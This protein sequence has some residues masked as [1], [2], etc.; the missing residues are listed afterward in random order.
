[1]VEMTRTHLSSDVETVFESLEEQGLVTATVT[2]T[3][4]RGPVAHQIRFPH[5]LRRGRWFETVRGP[6]KFFFFN[7]Y[8]SEELSTPFALRSRADG[9][10]DAYGAAVASTLVER[11]EFDFFL[12]YLPDLD[13]AAHAGGETAARVA[14]K[15]VDDHLGSL[16]TAA[17]GIDAFLDR[18]AIVVSSDHGHSDVHASARLEERFADLRVLRSGRISVADDYDVAVCASM[19]AGA[20]YRLPG[21]SEDVRQLARRVEQ[22]AAAD[23]V[24]FMEGD[25]TVARRGGEELRFRPASTG[26]DK[27]GATDMMPDDRYPDGLSRAWHALAAERSGDVLVSA[28]DGWEFVDL[29]D[30]D[31]VGGASHGGLAA[32]DSV[33]AVLA[34]GL[35]APLPAT[36]SISDFASLARTHFQLPLVA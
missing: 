30:G 24:L 14:L 19:R 5:A 28:A 7:L 36:L 27:T 2:F 4:F 13:Y 3:C 17:G 33:V 23:V 34:A 22:S 32:A 29:A 25:D 31:H 6:S 16:F 15:R 10:V 26:W 12:Y 35:E 9:S 21:C 8:E 20:V 11:D 18:Y 1:M